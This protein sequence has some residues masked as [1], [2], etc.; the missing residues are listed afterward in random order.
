[1][2]NDQ[3]TKVLMT[4]KTDPYHLHTDSGDINVCTCG[5]YKPTRREYFTALAFPQAALW[6]DE[7]GIPIDSKQVMAARHAVIIADELIKTLD[8]NSETD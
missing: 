1:M 8:K 6:A 4:E 7:Y 2:T 5:G 3:L